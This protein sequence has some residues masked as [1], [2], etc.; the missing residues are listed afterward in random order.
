M[1]VC[2]YV[3]IYLFI[4]LFIYS[5]FILDRGGFAACYSLWQSRIVQHR[6]AQRGHICT[7]TLDICTGTL[8]TYT[9]ALGLFATSTSAPVL[10][11]GTVDVEHQG[12]STFFS[13]LVGE[14]HFSSVEVRRAH[15]GKLID[16]CASRA[17]AM[18]ACTSS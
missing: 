12:E 13:V 15:L 14:R 7:G 1:Y 17:R 9:Y 5:L 6:I 4:Y 2:M 18:A 10:V 16:P 11:Q 8:V 3:F